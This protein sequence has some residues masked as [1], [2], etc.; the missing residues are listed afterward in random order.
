MAYY[1]HTNGLPANQTRAIAVDIRDE[2][3]KIALSFS[4]LPPS[5]SLYG[6]AANY[7]VDAGSTNAVVLTLNPQITSYTDGLS[8]LFKA[9]AS[10]TGAV[11]INVNSI[12]VKALNRPDG[13]AMQLGDMVGGQDVQATYNS[14]TGAFQLANLSNVA[15]N[16]GVQSVLASAG[17]PVWVNG[18]VYTAG[19]AGVSAASVVTSPTTFLAY[20]SKSNFT[21]TTDPASDPTNWVMVNAGAFPQTLVLGTSQQA[22]AGG[23][24]A[25]TNVAATTV[26]LPAS[27][28]DGDPP[29]YVMPANGRLD[30]VIARNGNLIMGLAED[31]VID[32]SLANVGLRFINSV[33][34]WRIV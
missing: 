25:L 15:I 33:I 16:A 30:N 7:A 27:P 20:R 22:Y 12:G 9:A 21:S 32:V 26:T 17:A 14:T 31:M 6:G 28:S 10:N 13:T 34:G 5:S 23:Q 24:Y 11:T 8:V 3:D 18:G 2:L 29:I 4:T 1:T 19:V